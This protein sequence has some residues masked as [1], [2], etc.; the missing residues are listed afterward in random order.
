MLTPRP[1]TLL[2]FRT[3]VTVEAVL[4]V[5]QPFLAGGFLSGN[6]GMLDLHAL[7]ASAVGIVCLL[8]IVAAVLLW[9]PGGGP[10]WPAQASAALFLAE[11]MQIGL[12]YARNLAIH[13]PLGTAIVACLIMMLVWS[14]RTSPAVE[15]AGESL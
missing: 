12:G 3:V 6:Y 7:N 5:L 11:G 15:A 1:W 2:L 10:A 9:R 4:G 14:W 8:Q 13:V